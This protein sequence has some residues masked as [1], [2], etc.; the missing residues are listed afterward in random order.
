LLLHARRFVVQ[1]G[2]VDFGGRQVPDPQLYGTAT[3]QMGP[4]LVTVTVTGT[5]SHP[6][7]SL[8]SEPPMSQADIL[9][10]IIFGRPAAALNRKQS[11]RLSAQA[12]ALLGQE[13]ARQI[14]TVLSPA[15]APDVVT[16][17]DEL[18]GGASLEAGKYLSPNLYLRYRHGLEQDSGQSVGLEYRFS[19]HFSLES[20]YGSTR[21]SGVDFLFS[22]DFD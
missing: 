20:Q 21:D 17:H 2:W 19:D 7:L 1:G 5:A 16:V 14:A 18:G 15:L 8:S 6:R 11:N 22:L 3:L 4:N 10:T 12:L 13:G 9:S